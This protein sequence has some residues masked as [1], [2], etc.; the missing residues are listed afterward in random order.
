MPDGGGFFV[1][2]GG[3]TPC[4]SV[5]G[6]GHQPRAAEQSA[7]LGVLSF[8]KQDLVGHDNSFGKRELETVSFVYCGAAGNPIQ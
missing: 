4:L 1:R 2:Q 7:A 8:F 5:H 3:L 6:K